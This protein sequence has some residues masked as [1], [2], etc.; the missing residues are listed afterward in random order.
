MEFFKE[1]KKRISE[2]FEVEKERLKILFD[3]FYC[4]DIIYDEIYGGFIVKNKCMKD[5]L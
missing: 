5:L 1:K 4:Y 2:V 3:F